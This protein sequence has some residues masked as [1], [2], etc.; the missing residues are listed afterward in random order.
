MQKYQN[1][2]VLYTT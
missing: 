2:D 1:Q